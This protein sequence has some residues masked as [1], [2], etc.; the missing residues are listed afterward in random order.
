M[1]RTAEPAWVRLKFTSCRNS[2]CPSL[3]S[4]R[5]FHDL[6]KTAWLQAGS[7]DERAINVGLGHE[8]G[9]VVGLDASAVLNPDLLRGRIVGNFAEHA[10]DKC[11]RFLRLFGGRGLARTDRPDGFVS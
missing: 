4:R 10:P 9:R 1:V 7:A 3:F 2:S 8:R 5:P 11:L 6:R